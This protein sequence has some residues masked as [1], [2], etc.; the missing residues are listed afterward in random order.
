MPPDT[1]LR[2]SHSNDVAGLCEALLRL[3]AHPQERESRAAATRARAE[4]F[5]PTWAERIGE[6]IQMLEQLG[7]VRN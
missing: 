7:T 2:V 3:D 1:N 5:I 6:E 4:S